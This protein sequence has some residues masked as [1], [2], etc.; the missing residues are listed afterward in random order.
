MKVRILTAI[1]LAA[2]STTTPP[3]R[4]PSPGSRGLRADQHL[5]AAQAHERRAQELARWPETRPGGAG[6]FDDPR[7]GLWYRRIDTAEEQARAAAGHRGAAADLHAES[8]SRRSSATAS[9]G[10][11]STTACG[12]SS[13]RRPAPPTSSSRRSAATARG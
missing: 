5:D 10:R 3:P 11:T 4:Q 9:A 1:A 2:C 7:G 8:P 12:C 6:A 13:V